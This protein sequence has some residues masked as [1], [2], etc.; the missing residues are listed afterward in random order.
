MDFLRISMRICRSG[1]FGY[2]SENLQVA[3]LEERFR[4]VDSEAVLFLILPTTNLLHTLLMAGP[5]P[6]IGGKNRIANEIIKFFPE[7]LTYVEVF[8]GG[9]QVFFHKEP[10]KVEV[11]NDLYG[12]VVNFYRVCQQHYE[13]FLRC[14]RFVLVSREWYELFEKQN[15]ESLTDVQR[16]VRFFYL[17]KTSYAGA[18]RNR[19]H[20]YSV[21]SRPSLNPERFPKVIEESHKRLQRVQIECLPYERILKRFDRPTTLF[22]LDPP[23]YGRK[24]Y[25]FNF[26]HADFVLLKDRLTNL[27]GKFVLS[28]NDVPEVREIFREFHLKEI[29]LAYTAQ[30][31]AGKR[32]PELL[33]ANYPLSDISQGTKS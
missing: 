31:K 6:Y 11:L 17:Q 2:L 12:E 10:S 22:Y 13:E 27:K 30:Q 19:T 28:L 29:E 18:V 14:L 7:H 16:A 33:I 25:Q 9:A 15:P 8:A 26:E 1:N 3:N 32:F 24:L 20:N 4:Q 23:Y 21:V 5:F